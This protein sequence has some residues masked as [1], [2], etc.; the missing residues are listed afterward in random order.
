MRNRQLQSGNILLIVM[1]IGMIFS[2]LISATIVGPVYL[3]SVAVEN[4]LA[5]VR[6]RWAILGGFHYAIS[7]TYHGLL[8][9]TAPKCKGSLT[10]ATKATILQ[11][12]F[13]E[14]SSYQ[15][16][17]YPDEPSSYVIN[18][19]LTGAVD[20]R[21]TSNASSGYLQMKGAYPATQSSLTSLGS[22]V[23]RMDPLELRYCVGLALSTS[24][25]GLLTANNGGA[26]TAFYSVSRL[27]SLKFG[28]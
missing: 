24:K 1:M 6:A 5:N 25:C 12:Y 3:E 9:Q 18:I 21:P 26:Q 20:D 4:E 2:V 15:T 14:I 17:T 22:A 7:R 19:T 10:D 13:N 11:G 28:S 16:L 23:G 27:S 8:C